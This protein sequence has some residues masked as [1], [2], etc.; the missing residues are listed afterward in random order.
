M[1]DF[2]ENAIELPKKVE[3]KSLKH[4]FMPGMASNRH[5]LL[6]GQALTNDYLESRFGGLKFRGPA[7]YVAWQPGEIKSLQSLKDRNRDNKEIFVCSKCGR[8]FE[9]KE[10]FNL[11]ETLDH[12]EVNWN[13][14]H[15]RAERKNGRKFSEIHADFNRF[16]K[17]TLEDPNHSKKQ[18]TKI[19]R[20]DA[21]NFDYLMIFSDV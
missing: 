7:E 16:R 5:G 20:D 17:S 8:F 21:T 1:V 10:Y 2:A 4:R 6:P 15:K 9:S 13:T 19:L 14:N 18:N 12:F 11:H 3:L